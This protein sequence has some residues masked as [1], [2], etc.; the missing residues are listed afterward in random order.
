MHMPVTFP[1]QSQPKQPG[2]EYILKPRPVSQDPDYKGTGKLKDRVA[3]ITGGDSG[4][5]RAVAYAFAEEGADIVIVFYNEFRDAAE[6]KREIESK[7]RRCLAIAGDVREP[8][9]C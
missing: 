1:P 8:G 3:I 6:T 9:F 7:G 5:G 4:I 2:L